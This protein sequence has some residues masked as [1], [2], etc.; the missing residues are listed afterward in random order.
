MLCKLW[1]TLTNI[2]LD[3]KE[4]VDNFVNNSKKCIESKHLY[5]KVTMCKCV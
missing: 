4:Y 2:I 5:N 1:I 3:L